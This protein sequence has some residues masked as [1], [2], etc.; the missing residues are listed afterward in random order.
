M[1]DNPLKHKLG[2]LPVWEWLLIGGATGAAL[3]LYERNKTPKAATEELAASTPN[4]FATPGGGGGGE[5]GGGS[6]PGI[7]G[8]I[9][10]PGPAGIPGVAGTPAAPA[11][12]APAAV[13]AAEAGNTPPTGRSTVAPQAKVIHGSANPKDPF[14]SANSKGEHF[15]TG[16]DSHGTYHEY[17]GKK[18]GEKGRR[19]YLTQKGSKA[20]HTGHVSHARPKP[21]K[22]RHA[23]PPAKPKPK[24]KKA[25]KH[26]RR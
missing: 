25:P 13:A 26:A 16:K 24:A 14:K 7:P 6:I 1:A 9:G 21:L 15:R 3:Y 8:P 10:E 5:T 12:V 2:P 22:A 17:I 11:E 20:G 23:K 4:P 18:S 19:V